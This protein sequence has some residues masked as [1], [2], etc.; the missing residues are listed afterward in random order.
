GLW[1]CCCTEGTRA[2]DLHSLPTRRSSDLHLGDVA[3]HLLV[4]RPPRR[5][6]DQRGLRIEQRDRPM[7]ELARRVALGVDV[8]ELL[9]LEGALQDRKSTRLNSSPVSS[10]Y[11]DF[12]LKKINE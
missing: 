8:G 7:L 2:G 10:S 1:H 9:E 3:H 12:C 11:A 6:R 4:G 5:H